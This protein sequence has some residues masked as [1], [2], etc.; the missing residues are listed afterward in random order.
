M[1]A[2]IL[3]GGLGTRLQPLV[4]DVPKSMA[5]VNQKPFLEYLLNY[6]TGQDV[7]RVILAVGYRQETIRAYFNEQFHHLPI[8][9]ATEEE[10]LGTGGGILNAM[11]LA[12]TEQVL[13]LNGDSMFRIDLHSLTNIHQFNHADVTLALKYME[14]CSRYGS[15][16]LD[17]QH[18][19]TG[20]VEKGEEAAPGYINAGVYV[21]RKDFLLQQGF[22]GKFSIEKDC[23][24]KLYPEKLFYGHPLK[25]YFLDIGIPEDYL[26]AQDQFR[27]YED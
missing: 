4:S 16:L 12:V 8:L 20:F 18:R 17:G 26:R 11:K 19:I 6:L 10:P 21:F 9:Y 3:A 7:T 27:F 5:P 1:D 25:G 14:D 13:V 22:S 23:F 15:V 2:I 24:E